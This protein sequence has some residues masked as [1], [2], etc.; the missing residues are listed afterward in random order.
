MH[1]A[2]LAVLLV[3]A[4]AADA[5]AADGKCA[6][7][8]YAVDAAG[9]VLHGSKKALREAAMRGDSLRVG[10]R[11]TFGGGPRD[12]VQHWADAVFVTIFEDD[13][14][15]QVPAIHR[16]GPER[17]KSHVG[18]PAQLELW[19]A[20]LG[21]NGLLVERFS[22]GR[23]VAQ[24]RIAQVWCLSGDAAIRCLT[25]S[26]RLVYRH[27]RDGKRLVGSKEALFAAVR[28]G[29]PIRLAWGRLAFFSF[30]RSR[31]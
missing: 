7:P 10:W 17:G 18:F 4:L 21:S 30:C 8:I 1:R 27:D 29:A 13:V 26:W 22:G 25:P 31:Q 14:F 3:A 24:T 28:R 2:G 12:V 6:A 5:H 19:H 15:T 11:L 9:K 16:Q 20:S 23:D